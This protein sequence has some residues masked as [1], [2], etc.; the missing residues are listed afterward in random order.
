ML[1][2]RLAHARAGDKGT[3]SDITLIAYRPRHYDHL[4]RFV[5]GERVREH[6]A[7]LALVAVER[8]EL[9]R[10]FALKFVLRG[11]LSGVTRAPDLDAHGKSLSSSLLDLVVPDPPDPGPVATPE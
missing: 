7:D 3:T 1:L 2:H 8:Y 5:T 6:F 9:P 11:A 10:L 4:R